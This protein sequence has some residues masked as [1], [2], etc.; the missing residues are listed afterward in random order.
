MA[1]HH[2]GHGMRHGF[3]SR[4]Q[5]RMFF[6]NPHLRKWAKK[7]AHKVIAER[8]KVTGFRSLPVRK[9]ARKRA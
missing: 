3:T 4:A 9:G 7:E 1:G 6:A 8:G 2:G 5:W